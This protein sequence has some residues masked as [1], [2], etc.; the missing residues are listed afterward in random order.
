MF[1]FL[2]TTHITIGIPSS[3]VMVLTGKAS[4]FENI[5]HTSSDIAPAIAAAGNS[6]R[7][8]ALRKSMRA[9]C[10]IAKPIKPIGPQNAVTVPAN[11]VVDSRIS[12]RVR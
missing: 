12:V 11:N 2:I 10:G 7:W 4:S 3:A 1:L 6:M 9:T 8:S 5:S